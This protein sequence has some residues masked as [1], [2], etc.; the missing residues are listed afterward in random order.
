[1]NREPLTRRFPYWRVTIAATVL[2]ILVCLLAGAGVANAAKPL[3]RHT[4][5]GSGWGFCVGS[6]PP[7]G[8]TCY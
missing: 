1:M 2:T 5:D 8:W 3:P 6:V 4:D 7:P